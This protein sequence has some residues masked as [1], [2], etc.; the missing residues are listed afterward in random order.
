MNTTGI[1]AL[2]TFST[3]LGLPI[4]AEANS[5]D[6]QSG[7]ARV[8]I[9]ENGR[10]NVNSR[11]ASI[12]TGYGRLYRGIYP[13]RY[14]SLYRSRITCSGHDDSYHRVE[15]NSSGGDGVETYSS[16]STRVCQ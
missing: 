6:V 7:S 9:D 8:T 5:V 15:V 12:D 13:R 11:G 16:S 1:V 14:P 3:L 2:L 10:V 4:I